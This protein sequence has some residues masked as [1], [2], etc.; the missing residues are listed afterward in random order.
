MSYDVDAG[1][2]WHNITY[3]LHQ[4]FKDFDVY[5]PDWDGKPRAEVADRIDQALVS[6]RANRLEALK[7]EYDA[8]NGWGLVE[9]GIEFLEQV[10]DSCRYQLPEIVR[11]S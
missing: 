2:G 7:A 1:K 8:P 6:I 11:V 9:H 5:P 10:R 3:N 4:F